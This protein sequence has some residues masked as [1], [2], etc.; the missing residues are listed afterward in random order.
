MNK[1]NLTYMIVVL[2]ILMVAFGM[3][4]FGAAATATADDSAN[5]QTE[6]DDEIFQTLDQ[7][8]RVTEFGYNS[9]YGYMII[10]IE[11][12]IDQR[13]T[14]TDA[15]SFIEGGEIPRRTTRVRA[16]ETVTLRLDAT[17]V[18]DHVVAA[19]ENQHSLYAVIDDRSS[20]IIGGPWDATDVR[21]AALFGLLGGLT[22]I[23]TVAYRRVHGSN[24]KQE[25]V[26]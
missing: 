11:S 14:V 5:N 13:I 17:L 19:V 10:Q 3:F 23:G 8:T 4:L 1:R 26:L 20:A 25:R 18:D 24:N 21:L 6:Q 16:G 9:T 2:S 22:I 7:D 15:G 12:D